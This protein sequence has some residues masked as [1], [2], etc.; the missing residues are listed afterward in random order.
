MGMTQRASHM[1]QTTAPARSAS[2]VS[3]LDLL[4]TLALVLVITDHVGLYF[5]E[6]PWL[7][8]LGRPAAVI[9]GFL[10]GLSRSTRVPASWIGL[11]LGLTLLNDWLFPDSDEAVLDIL[12]SL[13]LT[14]ILVPFLDRLHDASPFWMAAL[15]VALAPL[16]DPVNQYLEYGTEVVMMAALGVAV[17]LDN[18]TH[19]HRIARGALALIALGALSLISIY[20]F[21]FEGWEAVACVA[22]LALTVVML[23]NFART[24]VNVPTFVAPSLRFCGH[25]TLWIYALHLAAF[26]IALWWMV[27]TEGS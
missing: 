22:I 10:I 13:A 17:R 18:G 5:Y 2:E 4:K 21:E 23:A 25:N 19:I 6:E 7:R 9:F 14:R 20:H 15:A 11:G 27:D 26:Q 3:T 12:I 16:T 24:Q 1:S 8:V